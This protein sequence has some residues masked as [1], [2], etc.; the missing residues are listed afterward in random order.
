MRE[1]V[2]AAQRRNARD[3]AG[4]TASQTASCERAPS[5]GAVAA[6]GGARRIVAAGRA[7]QGSRVRI[8]AVCAVAHPGGAEIGLLRLA[9]RLLAR[10]HALTLATPGAGPLDDAGLPVVRLALGGLERGA[11]A[12]A[13]GALA[14][15]APA[16]RA[17]PTSSTST[18]RS[19]AACCPASPA[20]ARVL[21]VHDIVD[22]V[23]RFWS[24]ADA[25]LADSRAVADAA[26]PA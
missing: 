10:G 21:H 6:A 18:A 24:R 17:T 2:G 3:G 12:R 16:R 25:V 26:A 13:V 1:Q 14:A 20:G 15:R 22:R 5:A 4:G 9:R 7:L 8:L 19:A 11:G 23:P